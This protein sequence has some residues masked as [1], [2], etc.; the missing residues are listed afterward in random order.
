MKCY[1]S[2]LDREVFEGVTPL[3]GMPISP[4]EEA[5]P[6]G[7]MAV[8]AITPQE[9]AVKETSQKPVKER[10]CPK[11]PGWEKVLHPSQPVGVAGQSPHPSR[12]PEWTYLLM[13]DCNQPMKI[14]PPETPSPLQELEVAHQ[15][16]PT[17][18]FLEVTAC[19]S[20]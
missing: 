5:E 18:G 13:V 3:E 10:K 2:F 1:L 4:V 15:W 9:Q 12:S 8:P 14:V 7:M 16:M 17:P 6:H 20:G 19:L 11:F